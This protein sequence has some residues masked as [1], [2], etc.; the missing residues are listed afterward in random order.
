VLFAKIAHVLRRRRNVRHVRSIFGTF[1]VLAVFGL[2][3]PARGEAAPVIVA[4]LGTTVNGGERVDCVS[5]LGGPGCPSGT[6]TVV[7]LDPHWAWGGPDYAAFEAAFGGTA[8]A[9]IS[10]RHDTGGDPHVIPNAVVLT[11]S[12]PLALDGSY[13]GVLR[14]AA[15]DSTS[16]WL[17][18]VL[19]FGEAPVDGNGYVLCSDLPIGCR[20]DT[21]LE[22]PLALGAGTHTLS[23]QTAQ[24]RLA[25]F[26][27]RY[28]GEFQPAQVSEPALLALWGLALAWWR[29]AR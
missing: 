6:D 15:D 9:W 21:Y 1:A 16:V 25:A 19:I 22:L 4:S 26:G 24:R 11:F 5:V 8:S 14:V 20:S 3:A 28:Y 7:V 2:V 29:R 10:H 13:T 23:F 27:L 17:N 18:G 12:H